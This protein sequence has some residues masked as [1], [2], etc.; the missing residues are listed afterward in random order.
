MNGTVLRTRRL[1]L[2]PLAVAHAEEMAAVL[3]DP[4]LHTFIGGAPLT[5]PELRA[6]Y[7]RLTAGS[8]DPAVVW[9]NWVVRLRDEDRLAGTVQATVTD[10]GRVAEIAWVV[11]TEWQGRGIAREAARGLVDLLTT[12]GVRTV[13]AHVHPEHAASAAVARAAG[14]TATE[15]R[16]DGEIRW[17]LGPVRP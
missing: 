2:V 13:L 7:E 8:P 9:A 12:Q 14:L 5:A 17:R 11:G 4:A 16:E 15:E 6:R 1:D 3:A 10:G